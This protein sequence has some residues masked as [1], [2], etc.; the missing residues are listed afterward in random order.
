M[1]KIISKDLTLE[2]FVKKVTC[3]YKLLHKFSITQF[4]FRISYIFCILFMTVSIL[5]VKLFANDNELKNANYSAVK[6]LIFCIDAKFFP[7][8][9]PETPYLS[10]KP[11]CN[12]KLPYNSTGFLID[13]KGYIITVSPKKGI[14]CSCSPIK[15]TM[16]NSDTLSARVIGYD[17]KTRITVLKIELEKTYSFHFSPSDICYEEHQTSAL[18][19]TNERNLQARKCIITEH[20]N[21]P[22]LQKITINES[23][24]TFGCPILNNEGI[25]I[26]LISGVEE[27][28]VDKNSVNSYSMI[29]IN[30]ARMIAMNIIHKYDSKGG[31]LGINCSCKNQTKCDGIRIEEVIPDSPA[32]QYGIKRGDIIIGLNGAKPT[33][34]FHLI[35]MITE[36]K[37]G[38]KVDLTIQRNNTS[39]TVSPILGTKP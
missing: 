37:P 24:N 39:M 35:H 3:N 34:I 31:W 11:D 4:I 17:I 8:T 10:G 27:N 36:Q 6:N 26:G 7:F 14:I 30:L 5:P 21:K 2:N 29:P 22:H 13:N 23:L 1:L 20:N 25:I 33:D 9:N 19:F 28:V 12:K 32:D 38:I 18:Y 16:E 15:A